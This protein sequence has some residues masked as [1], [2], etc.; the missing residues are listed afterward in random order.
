MERQKKHIVKAVENALNA[1]DKVINCECIITGKTNIMPY[2]EDRVAF[3]G[4]K[5]YQKQNG[6]YVEIEDVEKIM[7]EHNFY[8]YPQELINAANNGGG[9]DNITIVLLSN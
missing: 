7:S 6:K 9:G 3:H 2:A 5:I 8:E 1:Y 4:Y